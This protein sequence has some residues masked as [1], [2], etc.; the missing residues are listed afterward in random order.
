MNEHS[1]TRS[2]I[3]NGHD[4]V[5]TT[6]ILT[7]D[8]IDKASVYPTLR[9]DHASI[10]TSNHRRK[11]SIE[12]IFS[13][14]V[15]GAEHFFFLVVILEVYAIDLD[16]SSPRI[17]ICPVI[18]LSLDPNRTTMFLATGA[19]I[20]G[21]HGSIAAVTFLNHFLFLWVTCYIDIIS[22]II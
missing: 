19:D 5:A 14:S 20:F 9:V 16:Y 11:D 2:F 10:L 21:H 6:T 3:G 13:I 4:P 7:H 12:T 1:F 22:K 15:G 8:S 17:K 18:F